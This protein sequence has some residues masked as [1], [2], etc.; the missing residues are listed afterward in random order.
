MVDDAFVEGHLTI[1]SS[2]LHLF[3]TGKDTILDDDH[4]GSS[5]GAAEELQMENADGVDFG[6]MDAMDTEPDI[7]EMQVS[8]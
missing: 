7:Q 6:G 3:L 2:Q 8:P 4:E 5:E 1:P